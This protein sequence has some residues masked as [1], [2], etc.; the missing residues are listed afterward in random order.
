MSLHIGLHWGM[1]LGGVR[2][3]IREKPS[4]LWT[5]V[6]CFCGTGIAGYGVAVMFKRNLFSYLFY[7]THFAMFDF[8]EPLIFFFADYVAMMGALIFLAYYSSRLLIKKG[9]QGGTP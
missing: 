1:V 9:R 2:K 5:T 6:L 4:L 8:D 3:M 7:R